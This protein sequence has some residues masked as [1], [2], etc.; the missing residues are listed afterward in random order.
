MKISKGNCV[1]NH[2]KTDHYGMAM[3]FSVIGL[4]PVASD[5][6]LG[7]WGISILRGFFAEPKWRKKTH[8]PM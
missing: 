8:K 3:H 2:G 5:S 1:V 7:D 4:S 6:R